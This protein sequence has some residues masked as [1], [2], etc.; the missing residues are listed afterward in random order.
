MVKIKAY[1]ERNFTRMFLCK[2][3][4]T[5][6]GAA[7]IQIDVVESLMDHEGYLTEG[8]RLYSLEDLQKYYLKG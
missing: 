1:E 7:G 5:R 8:Y 2:F 3:F 4:K 6:L